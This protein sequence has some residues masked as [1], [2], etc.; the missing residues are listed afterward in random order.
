[1]CP[2]PV[3]RTE[4]K[5]E[6]TRSLGLAGVSHARCICTSSPPLPP[7]LLC[8]SQPRFLCFQAQLEAKGVRRAAISTLR[9]GQNNSNSSGSGFEPA[10]TAADVLSPVTPAP[11]SSS[12]LGAA[13][14]AAPARLSTRRRRRPGEAGGAGGGGRGTTS[15]LTRKSAAEEGAPTP[16]G[17]AGAVGGRGASGSLSGG[18]G[19]AV[20]PTA[21]LGVSPRG[22]GL[23]SGGEEESAFSAL[24][25]LVRSRAGWFTGWGWWFKGRRW[26]RGG[27]GVEGLI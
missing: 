27:E 4:L 18:G 9:E 26:G 5:Q 6:Y 13:A 23:A 17:G 25:P 20:S 2:R 1:M 19:R 8:L 7:S 16:T 24:E 15:V 3:I 11:P 10:A 14:A 22:V 12:R 21:V